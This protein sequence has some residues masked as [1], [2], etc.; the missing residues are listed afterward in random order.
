MFVHYLLIKRGVRY[1]SLLACSAIIALLVAQS[2]KAADHC[3]GQWLTGFS[4]NGV[5]DWVHTL[6]KWDQDGDGPQP[7]VLLIGGGFEHAGTVSAQNLAIWDGQ[8][9]ATFDAMPNDFVGAIEPLADGGLVIAGNFTMIGIVPANGV[10]RW[11]GKAWSPLGSGVNGVFALCEMPNGDIVAAGNFTVAGGVEAHNIARWDGTTWSSMDSG[12]NNWVHALEIFEGQLVAGGYFTIAGD[13]NANHVAQ[14]DGEDWTPL[15][16][17]ASIVRDFTTLPNGDLVAVGGGVAIWDGNTWQDIHPDFSMNGGINAVDVRSDG[18]LVIGGNFN[19]GCS[20]P[21][22]NVAIWNGMEW[23]ASAQGYWIP[24]QTVN[25]LAV[26]GKDVYAGGS[27]AF[28]ASVY[29]PHLARWNGSTWSAVASGPPAPLVEHLAVHPNGDLIGAGLITSNDGTAYSRFGRWDGVKWS[30][31]S[32]LFNFNPR[33]IICTSGGDI[34]SNGYESSSNYKILRWNGSDW[35]TIAISEDDFGAMT[36]LSNGDLAAVGSFTDETGVNFTGIGRWNGK[37]WKPLETNMNGDVLALTLLPNGDV[38]AAGEF[39][40]I[41]GAQANRIAKWNGSAWLPF[42]S[43]MNSAVLGV[44]LLASGEIAAVGSFTQAD[45]STANRIAVWNGSAWNALGNG[46]P[47][48]SALIDQLPNGDLI[49]QSGVGGQLTQQLYRWNGNDW[50]LFST[51]AG[52]WVA[53]DLSDLQVLPSGE[54]VVVG[55]FYVVNGQ[56]SPHFARWTETNFPVIAEQPTDAHGYVGQQITLHVIPAL[57]YDNLGFQWLKDG[58][59]LVDGASQTGSLVV[60]ANTDTISISNLHQEDAGAYSVIIANECGKVTSDQ[61]M[62]TVAMLGDITPTGGNGIVDVDDLLA[63]I[64]AW[65]TCPSPCAADLTG[66]ATVDF[67]D[68]MI[69]INSWS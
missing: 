11:D 66:E 36:E 29:A 14:W 17:G 62:L 40:S 24:F 37:T 25:G 67:A 56:S 19:L 2:A 68:L 32:N 51:F 33:A 13:V 18:S 6:E 41:G 34:V 21:C 4:M 48:H 39:T 22:A 50:S 31:I 45:N 59:P 27:F 7:P 20:P 12:M 9:F 49:A 61:A 5:S 44:K 54:L 23:F 52:A 55:E 15:A 65:G 30:F 63:V 26:V 10:A 16:A 46:L 1:P 35:V 47:S 8:Q 58:E 42:G 28:A 38:I 53:P 60:G 57:G 3:D 43:G 64:N 69:V